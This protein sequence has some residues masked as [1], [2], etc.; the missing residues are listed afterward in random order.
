MPAPVRC[1]LDRPTPERALRGRDA[2]Q[3]RTLRP[4]AAEKKWRF[5]HAEVDDRPPWSSRS[6][7]VNETLRRKLSRIPCVRSS[8]IGYFTVDAGH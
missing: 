4:S 3:W 7:T 5:D 6:R 2:W 8:A 1:R